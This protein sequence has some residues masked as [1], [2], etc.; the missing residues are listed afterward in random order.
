VTAAAAGAVELDSRL[1]RWTA[2]GYAEG[3]AVIKTDR[4][5]QRQRPAGIIDLNLTGDVHPAVRCYVDARSTVGGTPEHADGFGIVNLNDTFQDI[6]PSLDFDE[7]YMDLFLPNLDVRIGKQ[8]IA[9]GRLDTFHPTD[10][11]NPRRYTDPFVT[12]EYDAKIGVPAV[13]ASLFP[14]DPT[15]GLLADASLSLLWVPIAIPTLF[16]TADERWF[17]STASV[18]PVVSIPAGFLGPGL[19]SATIRTSLQT[20]NVVPTRELDDGAAGVR[21]AAVSRGVDWSLSY[22]DGPETAP[23]FDFR[24]AVFS[25]SAQQKVREGRTPTIADLQNLQADTTL[26]PRF[27]RIRLVG[28]DLAF[29]FAGVTARM[30]A[31][32]G[33]HRLL[34]RT[35]E[36][37]VSLQNIK[38]AV[39][40]DLGTIITRLLKGEA[41]SID[42]GD[43]F[44]AR[45]TV[46]WGAGVDYPHS[47]WVPVL[48]VNQMLILDNSTSLLITDVDTR[49][50]AALRKSFLADRLA[51]ELVA[52]QGFERSYTGAIARFAY[53][54]TEN[55]RVRVGYLFI[56][57]SRHTLVGQYHGND[58]VFLQIRYS[59]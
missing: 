31:V 20:E 32:Y 34:P 50:F 28:G 54:V 41:V 36:D 45:D 3:Y 8:K 21:L 55:L 56:A 44:V 11:V 52:F 51:T 9:W 6:S 25:P 30:E 4:D 22:Y 5:S 26:R 29:Q 58:E 33:F 23:A 2:R 57:G 16:P 47:G 49:L 37:L 43:L 35:T 38:R 40:P 24:A 7:G 27:S 15:A 18:P 1:G 39:T 19:P 46:E 13:R 12:D 42:L 53:D 48:Q 10:V 14:P 59:H 17:P